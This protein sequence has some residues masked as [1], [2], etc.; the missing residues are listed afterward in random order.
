M[1]KISILLLVS[2]FTLAITSL[3]AQEKISEDVSVVD[4]NVKKECP[5]TKK[6]DVD[7]KI[8]CVKTG[9]SCS[10]SCK[11]KSK[12]TCCQGKS[13]KEGGFDFEKSNN[14]GEKSSCSKSNNKKRCC[15]KTNKC[16]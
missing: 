3:Y 8:K 4:E 7:G 16:F 1:K 9:K 5:Y 12:G 13:Q 10:K 15:K 6:T 2:C 11:N 14:Y